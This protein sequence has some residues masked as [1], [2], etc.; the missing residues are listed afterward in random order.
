METLQLSLGTNKC[1]SQKYQSR[2]GHRRRTGLELQS[3]TVA[4]L[5]V[6]KTSKTSHDQCKL[7]NKQHHTLKSS[8]FRVPANLSLQRQQLSTQHTQAS[9]EKHALTGF[10]RWP[11]TF[12]PQNNSWPTEATLLMPHSTDAILLW[13]NRKVGLETRL[14]TWFKSCS[15]Q[16]S[17]RKK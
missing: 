13:K 9:K 11:Y 12:P 7:F 2:D 6:S 4:S 3:P 5:D 15:L 16:V 17:Y 10:E 1:F 8:G 14:P